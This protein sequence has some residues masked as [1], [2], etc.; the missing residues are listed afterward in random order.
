[1]ALREDAETID[2]LE[3]DFELDISEVREISSDVR[4]SDTH[5]DQDPDPD[6]DQINEQDLRDDLFAIYLRDACQYPLLSKQEEITLGVKISHYRNQ[7][8]PLRERL[9]SESLSSKQ[10][11]K[12]KK[13]IR[14]LENRLAP[15]IN[16]LMAHNLRLVVS[17]ARRNLGRGMQM[18]DLIQEGNL[19]MARA[20][21]KFDVDKGYRFS[22]YAMWWIRQ[23]MARAIADKGRDVRMPIHMHDTVNQ[24]NR[25]AIKFQNKHGRYPD[26]KEVMSHFNVPEKKALLIIENHGNKA[27]SLDAPIK[28]EDGGSF[29]SLMHDPDDA[30]TDQVV[31]EESTREGINNLLL[32]NLTPR[33]R[34][35]IKLRFGLDADRGREDGLTLREI[36]V[37]VKLTRERIRQLQ[38]QALEKLRKA[39][40]KQL[41]TED[42]E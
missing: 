17:V 9:K 20:A 8:E 39:I 23:T 24:L 14:I 6:L 21:Y 18:M 32:N 38:E 33:E 2:E 15:Y 40:R 28:D 22:T 16:Q 25:F 3:D 37:E 10:A 36:G 27:F 12:I 1:M 31:I 29:L 13:K 19:G 34:E 41:I 42:L 11:K 35:V 26:L 5:P 7:I 30:T 4:L